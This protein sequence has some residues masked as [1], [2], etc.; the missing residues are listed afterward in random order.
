[1]SGCGVSEIAWSYFR[2][3]LAWSVDWWGRSYFGESNVIRV[4]TVR[5]HERTFWY[6]PAARFLVGYSPAD[7]ASPVSGSTCQPESAHWTACIMPVPSGEVS[8]SGAL[9]GRL[10]PARPLEVSETCTL[11]LRQLDIPPWRPSADTAQKRALLSQV[12]AAVREA[13]KYSGSL[14][15]AG[16][17]D[18]NILDPML[19]AVIEVKN[20]SGRQ[21]RLLMFVEINA[22]NNGSAAVFRTEEAGVYGSGLVRFDNSG[23]VKKVLANSIPVR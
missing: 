10:P 21:E 13:A 9:L 18:F 5:E 15:K 8:S 20:G 4:E 6:L 17:N 1:V 2:N 19:W 11:E 7:R 14:V 12:Q 3:Y 16:V 23:T 22:A